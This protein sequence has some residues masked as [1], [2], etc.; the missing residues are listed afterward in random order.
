V[1]VLGHGSAAPVWIGTALFGLALAPQYPTMIAFAE[2]HLALTGS[3][4]AWFVAASAVGSLAFPWVI[5]QVFAGVGAEALPATVLAASGVT[6]VWVLVV[7]RVLRAAHPP[8]SG[9]GLVEVGRGVGLEPSGAVEAAD[10]SVRAL[11]RHRQR[12]LRLDRR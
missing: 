2:R 11:R 8:A 6:L 5:G 4:T 9:R 12:G 10:R 1:L 7:V 3:A